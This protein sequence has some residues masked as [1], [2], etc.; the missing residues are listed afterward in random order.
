MVAPM[1]PNVAYDATPPSANAGS[2]VHRQTQV[3]FNGQQGDGAQVQ[4]MKP[5]ERRPSHTLETTDPLSVVGD[6]VDRC[7]VQI[8][9]ISTHVVM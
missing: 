3:P 6:F 1:R 2:S 7:S 4:G 9:L 8:I 5:E